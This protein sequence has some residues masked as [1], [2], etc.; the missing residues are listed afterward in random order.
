MIEMST[1]NIAPITPIT[2]PK[3]PPS[4]PIQMP[5]AAIQKGKVKTKIS[6]ISKV[7]DED[8][9]RVAIIAEV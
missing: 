6:T 2:A 1:P 9:L 8:E 7:L 4:I 3:T 5:A